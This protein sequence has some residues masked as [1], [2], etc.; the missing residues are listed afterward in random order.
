MSTHTPNIPWTR[1]PA[2]TSLLCFLSFWTGF[3][4]TPLRRKTASSKPRVRK[5]C[6]YMLLNRYPLR[7][8]AVPDTMAGV[9]RELEALLPDVK[10]IIEN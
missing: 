7:L 10:R 9:I 6:A 4:P 3:A 2:C 5:I 1:P 8:N